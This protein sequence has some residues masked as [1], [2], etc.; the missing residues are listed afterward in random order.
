MKNIA[1]SHFELVKKPDF[2]IN[3]EEAMYCNFCIQKNEVL[4]S[5]ELCGT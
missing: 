3:H 1:E 2:N 5:P 4:Y